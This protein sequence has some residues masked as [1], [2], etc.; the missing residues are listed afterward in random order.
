VDKA[1][2]RILAP[3]ILALATSAASAEDI[4]IFSSN[5]NI[6]AGAPNVLLIIDNSANWNTRFTAEK[7]AV[8]TIVSSLKT[9]FNLGLMLA[10][11]PPDHGSYVRFAIQPMTDSSGNPTAARDCLLKMVGAG[12]T[13]ASSNPAYTDLDGTADRSDAGY[14]SL[15][16]AEAYAYFAG[17]DAYRGA[18]A[19]L[20]DPL[21]FVSGTRAGPQYKAPGGGACE[22]NYI[23]YI[24]N[25]GQESNTTSVD[26]N[27]YLRDAGG[28]TAAAL[29]S[30][31]D[32]NAASRNTPID[33][34][35]RFL[36]KVSTVQ[37]VTY[38]LEVDP[39]S[40]GLG[41]YYTA[42]YQSTG[43]EGKGGYFAAASAASIQAQLARIFNDIQAANSVFASA[44]LPLSA[45]NTGRYSNQ[46]YLGVFR[47][48]G[49]GGPRWLGNLKQY[50][51]GLDVN[52]RLVLLDADG[53]RAES[54]SGGLATPDARSFWTSKDTASA[55]DAP[56]ALATSSTNGSTNGFWYFDSKGT[57]GNFDSP[58]GEWV[59]K[60]GAA[61]QLR[62][63]YLGYGNRGGIGDNNDSTLNA[64]PAR[65]VL[66]C[67]G[68][69]LTASGGTL[70][71]AA[72]NRARTWFEV[73]NTAIDADALGLSNI[74]TVTAI[75]NPGR[76]VTRLAT[77]PE[78]SR[79]RRNPGGSTK[80]ATVTTTV[81]HGFANSDSVTISGA[82]AFD[83]TYV[84]SAAS[85]TQFEI[86]CFL[87]TADVNSGTAYKSSTNAFVTATAHGLST[88]QNVVISGATPTGF[89]NGGTATAI[90][91][92]NADTFT[93][94]LTAAQN[95]IATGSI[96]YTG[97]T[98]TAT[99]ATANGFLNGSSVTIA[100]A[101]PA[102]YNGTFT[103][104]N[105]GT[106]TFDYS[107]TGADPI[108]A[109]ATGTIT[110][111][112][113]SDVRDELV[114]WIRGLDRQDENGFKVAS[115]NTDV[116][117]SI[118]GDVLHSRPVVVN[119][120][121]PSSGDNIYLFYGGND[122]VFRAIKGGQAATDGK[123]QWAFIPQ[124]FFKK[125]LR[126]YNNSPQVLY[127]S[128]A[129]G[130]VPAPTK[131]DYFWDG[132]VDSYVER[133]ASGTVTKAH[134]YMTMR[135]G[136]R[137]IY[138]LD[139]TTPTAPKFLWKKGCTT[140]YPDNSGCD[141][142]FAELGQTW[143]KPTVIK[144]NTGST[145][146]TKL[147][148]IFGAGY[149]TGE[150]AESP[151]PTTDAV[152]RGVY[153]LDAADGT[154]L[155][156]AGNNTATLP[157]GV[158]VAVS[159]MNF[160]IPADVTP[161]DRGAR[162]Y[163]DRVYVGDVG[164]NLWRLDI[165]D[166]NTSNWTVW[167]IA[168]LG[169]RSS[170]ATS[171]KIFY[172]P[173]VVLGA[174]GTFDA[175]VIGT[176]DRE[177]PLA[178]NAAQ[179]VVNRFYM[180]KDTHTESPGANLGISDAVGATHCASDGTPAPCLFDATSNSSVPQAASG[181]F[182]TLRT[183]EKVVNAP[184]VIA[185][186]TIFATNQPDTSTLSCTGNLG[187][188]RRYDINFLT[189]DAG[190]G[191]TDSGGNAVRD[192]IAPGGGFMP[193]SISGVLEFADGS[194][195]TFVADNPLTPGGPNPTITAP[196]KRSRTYWRQLLE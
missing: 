135:R 187:I 89:N 8:A 36:N 5:T 61:Q 181:W 159:G 98:A 99:T 30:P 162:G 193:S 177:H 4:D 86:C 68:T 49:Q 139:V 71:T 143:S 150:D 112:G 140:D 131:R 101:L 32:S 21:A 126:L 78:I 48:D 155:W 62:L 189:G 123:E 121:S 28:A 51:F 2:K 186:E 128:T 110:A 178:S 60:G 91:V 57:G 158:S 111:T 34:W 88:G 163:T 156:A 19:P 149:D 9:Q 146:P 77:G 191:L 82:G 138:A 109:N 170:T 137:L 167:K 174:S 26:A 17:L 47:P 179:D 40:T 93:Y 52:G 76:S 117:A 114:R 184:L 127:S 58:D 166:S 24:S 12:T 11:A 153:V 194:V 118:H 10:H 79:I 136:G 100:G 188:A 182:V 102:A 75:T 27:R 20:G 157:A 148:L 116:R 169:D 18:N 94:A 161:M 53:Q 54:A 39:A 105:V 56:T 130:L 29:I 16:M 119:F 176:G 124:E 96:L 132:P 165:G 50:Q 90:T 171:R 190:G 69:C 3:L 108:L 175:I 180:V 115:Q 168:T 164:S 196:T 107:F 46:V 133:N 125:F 6:P 95:G 154:P 23:I 55:P 80:P 31:P 152:G 63:A 85:S 73:G 70:L 83:G 37:A 92:L 173:D 134:L 103:I 65:Q 192:E 195:H 44:S 66:T 87:A 81:A 144:L 72:A 141:P 22:K 35:A 185:S 160:A 142:G 172:S 64:N 33:E 41:P 145:P 104:R 106:T 14:G 129:A 7:A 113:S 13:C 122:G 45:D 151:M 147:A 183:G 25:G 74:L 42:L 84:I 1:I 38:T 15:A 43:R 67:I 97:N 59:E 120:G